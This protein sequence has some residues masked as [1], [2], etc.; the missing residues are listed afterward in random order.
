MTARLGESNVV[1]RRCE[2][3][4]VMVTT[5]LKRHGSTSTPRGMHP[6]PPFPTRAGCIAGTSLHAALTR[7]SHVSAARRASRG[8]DWLDISAAASISTS[9]AVLCD[10]AGTSLFPTCY[11]SLTVACPACPS[12]LAISTSPAVDR[13][14]G[15]RPRLAAVVPCLQ[16]SSELRRQ[17]RVAA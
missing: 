11:C 15:P 17:S 6:R 9:V 16:S 13:I 5:C 8:C 7:L 10:E 1:S 4:Q 14:V 3:K 12:P 2:T